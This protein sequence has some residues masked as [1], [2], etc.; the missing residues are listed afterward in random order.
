MA[1]LIIKN[2]YIQCGGSQGADGYMKYI[3]TRPR[4]ERLGDHGL[5]GDEDSVNLEQAM[6]E[7]DQY[8]GNVWTHILSPVKTL[9]QKTAADAMCRF[10][11]QAPK[12]PPAFNFPRIRISH[13]LTVLAEIVFVG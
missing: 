10:G 6:R 1:K 11:Q 2:P 5:F 13:D 12:C 8:T 3:A 4:A 9:R 7:L